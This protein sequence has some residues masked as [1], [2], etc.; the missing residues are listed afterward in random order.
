MVDVLIQREIAN[1]QI[2]TIKKQRSAQ[3][4]R[5]AMEQSK[6]TADMQTELAKS[7]VNVDIYTNQANARKAQADGEATFIRQTGTAK[8]AEVEAVGLARAKAYEAQVKALGQTPTALVNAINA[9]S[10]KQMKIVPD[11]FVAGGGGSMDG[12][13]AT[14]MGWLQG[15]LNGGSATLTPPA[16]AKPSTKPT[17]DSMNPVF[18]A[19]PTAVP[20]VK[21]P[22]EEK[23]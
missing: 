22:T 16:T 1:Q 21:K 6:G 4:E 20:E 13:A 18:V 8:G 9:L 2:E 17:A 11:I 19:T 14:L 23:K 7:Q 10:E 15:S 12:L 5:I 3:E